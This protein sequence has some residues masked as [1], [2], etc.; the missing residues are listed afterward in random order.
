[1]DRIDL[2]VST[3]ALNPNELERGK[4]GECSAAVRERVERA[5]RRQIDR[6]GKEN[7]RLEGD[8]LERHAHANEAARRRLRESS[9]RLMLSAR[10]HHR[11]LRVARTIA[12]LAGQDGID[13]RDILEALQYRVELNASPLRN[14]PH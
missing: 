1:M 9:E 8:E 6:Q 3:P 7:A 11:L 13:E 2:H 12:D 10:S 5:R 4:P 14:T